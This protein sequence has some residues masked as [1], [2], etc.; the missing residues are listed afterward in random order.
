MKIKELNKWINNQKIKN[1]M[2][3]SKIN[4]M[5]IL[6]WKIDSKKI[7]NKNK[8]FFSIIPFKFTDSQK[9]TWFQPLI[10][11]KEVGILG[12]L[13]KRYRS[14]DYY[15]LQAKVEPGNI[16]GIQLSP[17][18]QAT[19]SNYLRK[20]GGKK[21]NYLDFFIKKKNLNI[22]SNLK[23]SE[24]GFRYLDKSNKNIL[25]DIKNT[26]IKKIQNFIWVTKKNLNYLLNKKNLLNM[27]TISVLSSSIKKNNID[28][29]INKNLIISNN[30][31]KFKKR[32]TIKKKIISFGDLY[33]WKISKNK[34]SDIK[35]KFF[36]IIFLKIKTNS[37]EVSEW[38]QPIISDHYISFNGFL[39][40]SI[41]ETMHY[42]LQYTLEPG[43]TFPKYTSTVSIKNYNSKNNNTK[44]NF[45]N[46]FKKNNKIINFIN[47]DE[48]GRFY[49]NE[50]HNSICVLNSKENLSLKKNFIWV[51]HNQ[52][53]NLINKNLLSI[54]A[55]NLFASFNIDKI[56]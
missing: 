47:S 56:K 37:R 29:P 1:K 53:I 24:Q 49:K 15:L 12:I 25:I 35:S 6:N 8:S 18:V 34:I 33:N 31:T 20:H 22:V 2:S 19:K 45:F 42:L 41:N 3:I 36:S 52:V 16:N 14:L 30:L 11:Q 55:R 26:K 9:T 32:F 13:K 17:T 51:S 28:N 7:Y 27:D 50:T 21:T 5:D 23:L 39:V 10:I 44:I 38:F 40:R 43:F 54:E 48:G 46:F 4:I